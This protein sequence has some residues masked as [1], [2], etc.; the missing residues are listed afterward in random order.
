MRDHELYVAD[1]VDCHKPVES[2]TMPVPLRCTR[3]QTA[4]D[5]KLKPPVLSPFNMDQMDTVG[6]DELG[7]MNKADLVALTKP[8]LVIDGQTTRRLAVL[9]PHDLYLKLQKAISQ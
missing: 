4:L 6:M 3:C 2:R 8:L 5:D 1:C 7:R 9:M